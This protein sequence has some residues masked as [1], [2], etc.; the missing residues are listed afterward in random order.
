MMKKDLK[1][2]L[3]LSLAGVALVLLGLFYLAEET[4]TFQIQDKCGM[5]VNLFSHSIAGIGQCKSRCEQQC[6]A[7]EMRYAGIEFE[8]IPNSCNTCSCS[9]RQFRWY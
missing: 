5:F 7:K 3:T 6:E 9:C 2:T 4:Q 1:F 8:E